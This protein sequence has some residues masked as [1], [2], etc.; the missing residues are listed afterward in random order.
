LARED[1]ILRDEIETYLTIHFASAQ[2]VIT[3]YLNQIP[4]PDNDIAAREQTA[5]ILR[6]IIAH[7]MST[8]ET[9]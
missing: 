4:R 2:D 7:A 5:V 1:W 9:R 8:G 6:R 3:Q